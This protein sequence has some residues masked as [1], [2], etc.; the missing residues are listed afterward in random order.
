[1][2]NLHDRLL[3]EVRM[4]EHCRDIGDQL[5]NLPDVLRVVVERHK[6]V[7]RSP[8]DGG[9][10]SCPVCVEFCSELGEHTC[11]RGNVAA[12]CDEI[13]AIADALGV[14]IGETPK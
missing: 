10:Y 1:M 11:S 2:S 13:R 5:G 3:A 12:P 4:Y 7:P 8:L 6:P 14:E 9:G